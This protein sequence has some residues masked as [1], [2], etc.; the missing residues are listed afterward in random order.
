MRKFLDTLYNGSGF[1]AAG[2]IVLICL[3][4]SAQVVLNLI[5]KIFG[6]A[7]SM[8][9]PS[10]ADF[11]GFSLAAASF[12]ALAYTLKQGGHI[13]VTLLL[14]TFGHIPRLGAELFS[15]G[16]GTLLSGYATYYMIRLNYESYDYG[17]LSN[18][19]IAIPLWIP[20]LATS[21]GLLILTIAFIDL[22]VTTLMAREPVLENLEQE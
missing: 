3:V 10:Y 5:T 2:F 8:T 9:I 20:Q 18:G 6:S 11:A 21:A 17:D 16:L 15:L 19:I 1:A 13:R 7:Y 22:F 4:V 14:Q 12:L